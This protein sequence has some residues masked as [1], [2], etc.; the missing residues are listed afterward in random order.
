MSVNLCEL[1]GIKYPLIQ[2]G[3]AWVSESRL[4]AAVSNAGGLGTIASG[5]APASVVQQQIKLAKALTTKP[6]C[7]NIMLFSPHVAEIAQ[8]VAEE[9]VHAV[10]TGAGDPSQ[11][12]PMWLDAGIKV[13]PLVASVAQAKRFAKKG[14]TALIAE[15][16]EAGG[17]IGELT[18]MALVPQ[19]VDAVNV[20]VIAAG[21]IADG[22]GM[23]AA[24]MLGAAGVQ[25]GTR[26]LVAQE[27]HV[28]QVYKDKIITA[29]DI[30]TITTGKRIGHNVRALKTPFSRGFAAKERDLNVTE[31]TLNAMGAGAL[32]L[33][34]DGDTEN[35]CFMAGQI[36]GLVSQAQPAADI[37]NEIVTQAEIL[38]NRRF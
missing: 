35:G 26:F 30:S 15:G 17:H 27:C 20:P 8:L 12:M 21:G 32:K 23:A 28:H 36:A 7:V 34:V 16:C 22:R 6:F 1:L 11:Y 5:N 18:T 9:G 38:L 13:M 33:A 25:L 29:S 3:M 24:F 2:G 31:E 4:A 19:I 10:T 37:V 14:V